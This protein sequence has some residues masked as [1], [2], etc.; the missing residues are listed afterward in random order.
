MRRE[1]SRSPHP[2]P[3]ASLFRGEG[4]ERDL[5]WPSPPPPP[6]PHTPTARAPAAA[7]RANQRLPPARVRLGP[8]ARARAPCPHR[9]RARALAYSLGFR[10]GE[11][12]LASAL[13][14]QRSRRRRPPLPSPARPLAAGAYGR[15]DRPGGASGGLPRGLARLPGES[16][17]AGVVGGIPVPS[18]TSGRCADPGLPTAPTPY[19]SR[20]PAPAASGP[21][22]A[23]PTA[24]PALLWPASVAASIL[25]YS[26]GSPSTGHLPSTR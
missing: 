13:P 18:P 6:P 15:L 24:P 10:A 23:R 20:A 2:P 9:A 25:G 7:A 16:G 19:R 22:E 11:V 21:A 8:R 1:R 3:P 14:N 4:C 17:P 12:G 5:P 26:P